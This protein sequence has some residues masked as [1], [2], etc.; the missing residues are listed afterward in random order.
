MWI[1]RSHGCRLDEALK[2]VQTM[3][4]KD[5]EAIMLEKLG[6]YEEA[7]NL[8]LKRLEESLSLVMHFYS[9]VIVKSGKSVL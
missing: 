9:L 1:D 3:N 6:N 8:L 2:I 4:H 5:A 7:F